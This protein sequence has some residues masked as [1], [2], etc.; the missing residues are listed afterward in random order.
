MEKQKNIGY[1]TLLASL[2]AKSYRPIYVLCGEEAYDIDRIDEYMSNHIVDEMARE[3]DMSVI[4]GKD[5]TDIASVVA[6]AKRFP[7]MSDKLLIIVREA[8]Y[9]KKWDALKFYLEKPVESTILVICYKNE[10]QKRTPALLLSA[11]KYGGVVF[12]TKALRPW[13]ITTWIQ[14]YVAEMNQARKQKGQKEITIDNTSVALL[15]E[16][17]G[18][19]LS[20]IAGEIQKLIVGLPDGKYVITPAIIERNIGISKDYNFL[21][22]IDALIGSDAV[23]ANRI[24]QYFAANPKTHPIARELPSLF[25]FFSKLII[26]HYLSDKSEYS[27]AKQLQIS[28]S[29]VRKYA[30]GAQRFNAW[31][32]LHAI[33]WIREADAQSKGLSGINLPDS[34]IWKELIYKLLH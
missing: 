8:Q 34:E 31:K 18:T 3:F 33:S 5:I 30:M 28:P 26:Y 22:L 15:A 27:V 4:Y 14:N 2:Q 13:E 21:E 12:E 16:Y 19:D 32:T 24:V 11:D 23:K 25:N 1:N 10:P 6:N 20:K 9:I 17:L 29:F 7:M